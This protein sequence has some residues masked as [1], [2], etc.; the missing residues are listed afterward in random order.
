MLADG[1]SDPSSKGGLNQPPSQNRVAFNHFQD[2]GKILVHVAAVSS[3][4]TSTYYDDSLPTSLMTLW[5]C[6]VSMRSSSGN[7]VGHNRVS[8]MPRYAFEADTFYNLSQ[9]GGR[10]SRDNIFEYNVVD[11]VCYATTDTG[12]FEL[13]GSGDAS[14]VDFDLNNTIRYNKVSNVLGSS[15]SDG[16]HVCQNS[17]YDPEY[18]CR[19]IAWSIYLDGGY[20]GAHIYGNILD[21]SDQGAMI[22]NGGT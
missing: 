2:L 21:G 16:K 17:T 9:A 14:L 7:Y 10:I 13:L 5:F 20:S 19:G 18:G 15:S 3:Y 1:V 6:Q 8:H 4:L 22:I 11:D 12:A